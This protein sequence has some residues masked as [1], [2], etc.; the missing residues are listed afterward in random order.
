MKKNLIYAGMLLLGMTVATGCSNEESLEQVQNGNTVLA[1]IE[2]GLDARTSVND[3]YEVTWTTGDAFSVW[4][5]GTKAATLTLSG[6][7]G[8]TTGSFTIDNNIELTED[9]V[10]LFPTSDAMSYT[11]ATNY[12]SQETDAPMAG[13]FADGKFSFNLLTAMVRVVVDNVP[14]GEAVLTISS[15]NEVLTGTST[16]SNGELSVPEDGDKEVTVTINNAEAGTLTFDVPVPVQNYANGLSVKLTS[17]TTEIFSKKTNAID[18][19]VGKIY[20]L[21]TDANSIFTAEA[22]VE[23]LAD[24]GTVKLGADI[25]LTEALTVAS[26][27]EVTIDLDGYTLT[28]SSTYT[29][30]SYPDDITVKGELSIKNGSIAT[31]N[32]AFWTDGGKLTLSDCTITSNRTGSTTVGATN[33]ATLKIENCTANVAGTA[34]KAQG[35]SN[36]TLTGCTATTS[37]TT[38]S[39]VVTVNGTGSTLTIDGGSYTGVLTETEHDRYVIGVKKGATATINTTVQNGNGGVTVIGGSTAT[40]TGGSYSGGKACGLYVNQKSTVTYS[41]CTFSGVEGDV[42]VGGS[43]DGK[44]GGGTVNDTTYNDYTKIQ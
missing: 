9:M 15:E 7:A 42:V 31:A 13:S 36:M 25:V 1:V 27:Q 23:A 12:T 29:E 21:D 37:S 28:T 17:G 3:A 44:E 41:D 18:A 38:G 16:L 10:A 35:G 6:E 24:G 8:G 20:V 11:F 2:N 33:N 30:G 40:L 43:I 34:F 5:N 26:G 22:L 32:T 39:A 4:N 14:A 19:A